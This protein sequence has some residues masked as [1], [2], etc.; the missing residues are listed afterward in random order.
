MRP[1]EIQDTPFPLGETAAFPCQPDAN[2]LGPQ[3]EEHE[4]ELILVKPLAIRTPVE[5]RRVILSN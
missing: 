1:Q 5:A 4:H 3:R 2:Q